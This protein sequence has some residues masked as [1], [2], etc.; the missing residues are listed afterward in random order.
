MCS[1]SCSP[2]RGN[3]IQETLDFLE[4]AELSRYPLTPRMADA[5]DNLFRLAKQG[6]L[7]NFV[8]LT[9]NGTD[10]IESADLENRIIGAI[11]IDD[12]F[13][14]TGFDKDGADSAAKL[15]SKKLKFT[16]GTP[17]SGAKIFVALQ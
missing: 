12:I 1:C 15:A 10:T 17:A 16:D 8:I 6:T 4:S 9:A 2:I 5:F 14:M 13:K 11:A 3:Y 7:P